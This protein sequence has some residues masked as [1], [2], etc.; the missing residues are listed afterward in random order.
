[1]SDSPWRIVRLNG[2][3]I[4]GLEAE[5]HYRSSLCVDE[6]WGHLSAGRAR[7]GQLAKM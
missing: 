4:E 6:N 3:P 1:M 7:G 2:G 5:P